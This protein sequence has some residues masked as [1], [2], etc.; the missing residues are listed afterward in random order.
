MANQRS[1]YACQEGEWVV[2]S[3]TRLDI[4]DHIRPG[5]SSYAQH[6]QIRAHTVAPSGAAPW[7]A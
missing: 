4:W 5:Q 2:K 7:S 3:E 6:L 1:Q